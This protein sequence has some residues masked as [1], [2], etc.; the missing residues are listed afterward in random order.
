MNSIKV[1]HYISYSAVY[2]PAVFLFAPAAGIVPGIYAKYFYIE[3]TTIASVVLLVRLFD[4]VSDPLIGALSDRALLRYGTRKPWVVGGG[5][6]MVFC[7]WFLFSPPDDVTVPY[8]LFWYVSFYLT[9]TIFD[10][11]HAA[12]GAEISADYSERA[13]VFS[14]RTFFLKIS[15]ISFYGLPFLP[16]FSSSTYTPETLQVAAVIGAVLMLATLAPLVLIAPSGTHRATQSTESFSAFLESVVNNKPLIMLV[17][18]YA[19]SG[20]GLG[21]WFALHFIFF[22]AYLQFG[23]HVAL[24]FLSGS[25]AG[26]FSIPF[27]NGLIRKT[28]KSTAWAISTGLFAVMALAHSLF[29]PGTPVAIAIVVVMGVYASFTCLIIAVQSML[30]DIVDYGTLKFGRARAGGYYAFNT[31]ITKGSGGLGIA[32]ALAITGYFGFVPSADTFSAEAVFGIKLAFSIAPAIL[33]FAA[34]PIILHSPIT[35]Q[36]QRIIQRRIAILQSREAGKSV[37]GYCSE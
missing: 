31:L 16:L 1:K 28:S 27:W 9:W 32:L 14:W 23:D 13:M 8:L 29:V 20:F 19:L 17:T 7:A 5:V 36:R 26:V 2:A 10:I 6:L 33:S 22:D 21:M 3:L 4:A 11:S 30:G 34:I 37:S 24:V 18:A 15:N 35:E 25:I 12:W